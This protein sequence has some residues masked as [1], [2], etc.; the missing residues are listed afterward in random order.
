MKRAVVTVI[1]GLSAVAAVAFLFSP[2]RTGAQVLS[3]IASIAVLLVCHF[4]LTSLDQTYAAKHDSTGYWP[5]PIG[6]GGSPKTKGPNE[7]R[8]TAQSK[9]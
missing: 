1:K 3:F 2:L 5:K 8:T 9:P 4:A 6:W 7:E